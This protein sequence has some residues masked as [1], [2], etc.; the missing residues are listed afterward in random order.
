MGMNVNGEHY[1][2]G[3]WSYISGPIRYFCEDLLE[4]TKAPSG[5]YTLEEL[6]WDSWEDS[7]STCAEAMGHN[8][9]DCWPEHVCIEVAKTMRQKMADGSYMAV[10][11]ETWDDE[12]IK[13]SMHLLDRFISTLEDDPTGCCFT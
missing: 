13:L 3:Q 2:W 10:A 6:G 1:S 11:K 5:I 8:G 7:F 4:S 9:C 12:H